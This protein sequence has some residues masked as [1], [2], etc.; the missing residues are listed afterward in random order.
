[1][2]KIILILLITTNYLLAQKIPFTI[3]GEYKEGIIN[4]VNVFRNPTFKVD[5]III[6]KNKFT[7]KG[8]LNHPMNIQI[9]F[10]EYDGGRG[11]FTDGKT[12]RVTYANKPSYSDANETQVFPINVWGNPISKDENFIFYK[13]AKYFNKRPPSDEKDK[14]YNL[15]EKHLNKYP[16]SLSNNSLIADYLSI[17]T[18]QEVEQLMSKIP[19]EIQDMYLG[20]YIKSTLIKR[21]L[22]GKKII[23]YSLPD[24][25]GVFHPFIDTTKQYTLLMFWDTTCKPCRWVN[26]EM[27]NII[28][29]IDTDK[30]SVVG[31]SFETNTN[32]WKKAIKEDNIT[33]KQLSVINGF[34]SEIVKFLN[35]NAIP[36]DLLIDKNLILKA[37]GFNN[38]LK[39]IPKKN[40]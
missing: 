30:V 37:N 27:N 23:N 29:T 9:G 12:I 10:N 6:N 11:I 13:I 4:K 25:N 21:S 2:K 28:K 14:I 8:R 22:V 1:M 36:Y 20:H 31:L 7:L 34:E 19:T 17:G 3:H 38:S 15:I 33:W 32:T 16:N 40:L 5:T 26:K 24:T 35:F 39:L 18:S